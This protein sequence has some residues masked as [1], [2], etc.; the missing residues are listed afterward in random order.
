MSAATGTITYTI[1][2]HG[3]SAITKVQSFSKSQAADSGSDGTSPPNLSVSANTQVFAFDDASDNT[4][5]PTTATITLTQANQASNLVDSDVSVTN[6]SKSSFSY[7]GA[8]G[9]GT[10]TL[11]VTPSGT[12]PITVTVS[13]DGLS[14][15]IKLHKI[16]GG[17]DGAPGADAF[18]VI[19]T[20]ESHVIPR[21]ST[22][23]GGA[24]TFTN[25]GTEI[26]AFKGTTELNSVSGTPS[27]G[28]FKVTTTDVNID[29]S[30][31]T[32]SGN[33]F[34]FPDHSNMT[35]DTA[36][37]GY[38]I[39]LENTVTL[40][41]SHSFTTSQAADSGSDGAPGATG[42]AGPTGSAGA[43]VVHQGEWESGRVYTANSTRRD[44]VKFSSK[45]LKPDGVLVSKLFMGEDFLEV[46]DLAKTKFKKVQ[47]F[48]PESS[49]KE[50]KEKYTFKAGDKR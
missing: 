32:I 40:I 50:S 30:T 22:Q 34:V 43:G 47:F 38:S 16:V 7:S 1:T 3:A 19:L 15:T 35:A 12:Y 9:T 21:A 27:S 2:P 26:L 10:A 11:T 45:I 48:K 25:S 4:P 14:D 20:N 13:N 6:G 37:I 46:K 33:P 28:Q 5:N 18:T 49:R 24:R 44:V 8:N 36:T 23:A 41:K 29:A 42:S 17:A 31:G 39:N